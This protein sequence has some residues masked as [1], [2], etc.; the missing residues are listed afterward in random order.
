MIERIKEEYG[1]KQASLESKHQLN[2]EK[3]IKQICYWEDEAV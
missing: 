3:G 2:T 1:F